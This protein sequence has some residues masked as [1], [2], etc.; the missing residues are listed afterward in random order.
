MSPDI[1]INLGLFLF[2]LF[3]SGFF[4]S[5]E[6]AFT[7]LSTAQ[8]QTMAKKKGSRGALVARMTKEPAN[9]ITAIL[10]GNNLVNVWATVIAGTVTDLIIQSLGFST[11]AGFA[12]GI[13][14]AAV[15][16]LVLI[17]G[18][19]VPKQFA[20]NHNEGLT[21]LTAPIIWF[22]TIIFRPFIWILTGISNLAIRIF[23]Q[24]KR[25]PVTLE[26]LVQLVN[27]A[28][29]L[30]LLKRDEQQILQNTFRFKDVSVRQILTHR[31]E[32]FSLSEEESLCNVKEDILKAGFSRIP[33]FDPED[34]E[35]ITGFLLMQ[36]AL[37]HWHDTPE[38]LL[39][40]QLMTKPLYVPSSKKAKDLLEE[41][42]K[43]SVNLAIVLDEYGGLAGIVTREDVIEEIMGELYDEDEE[44][45]AQKIA[46]IGHDRYSI[47]GDTPI[48]A[49]NEELGLAL[50]PED[51]QSFGGYIVEQT[52]HIPTEREK[53]RLP[54]GTVIIRSMDKLQIEWVELNLAEKNKETG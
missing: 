41:F 21:L 51:A 46:F 40:R 26:G 1:L 36:D 34:P 32:V 22:L 27:L 9:L 8:I 48:Y 37:R 45:E 33:L 25:S 4:S 14:V 15:T 54:I 20:I 13:V 3:L 5:S 29:S 7:S 10:I 38:D 49:V 47:A 52:G 53:I 44:K 43:A 6:T 31:T 11:E 12:S 16:I 18:E 50:N 23:G 19:V 42:K 24:K 39:L 17:F 2:L 35:V 30:G 28:K